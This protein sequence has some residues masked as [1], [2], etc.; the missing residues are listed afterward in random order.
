MRHFGKRVNHNPNGVVTIR[1]KEVD[2][3]IYRNGLL[4]RIIQFQGLKEAGR[5]VAW[6]FIT[7]VFIITP[8]IITN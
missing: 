5:R 6:S 1:N 3:K 2:Y 4:R 8:D 7:L